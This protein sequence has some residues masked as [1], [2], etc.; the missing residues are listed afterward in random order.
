MTLL[1]TRSTGRATGLDIEAR[2]MLPMVCI[3]RP[4]AG[5]GADALVTAAASRETRQ[6]ASCSPT[7]CCSR[8]WWASLVS[9]RVTST[10]EAAIGVGLGRREARRL[11]SG[12][13]TI[14][15]A[16]PAMVLLA[17]LTTRRGPLRP[18]APRSWTGSARSPRASVVEVR[19]GG[20]GRTGSRAWWL[21]AVVC[22]CTTAAMLTRAAVAFR[23]IGTVGWDSLPG[24]MEVGVWATNLLLLSVPV[25]MPGVTGAV[26]SVKAPSCAHASAVTA[27]ATSFRQ[28]AESQATDAAKS[29]V[30][31][32]AEQALTPSCPM[33]PTA[34][35]TYSLAATLFLAALSPSASLAGNLK[36]WEIPPPTWTAP[37]PTSSRLAGWQ[38]H[39]DHMP[40]VGITVVA[41]SGTRCASEVQPAAATL[42]VILKLRATPSQI[43]CMTSG[44]HAASHSSFMIQSPT[45]WEMSAEVLSVPTLLRG[46]LR[47][48]PATEPP[49]IP[50]ADSALM[51][52]AAV[53]AEVP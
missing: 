4:K 30:P 46:A 2:R 24:A 18:P 22:R 36:P 33:L 25:I 6:E 26:V 20:V 16:G 53:G 45:G 7:L 39:V 42:P 49:P 1:G 51:G 29:R 19:C 11:S 47:E 44:A 12:R 50:A 52:A 17:T 21:P 32:V 37:P 34:L 35:L 23:G 48:R 14:F 43:V 10:A 40:E 15:H 3:G 41:L 27:R 9:W 8:S 38:R 28:A 31:V 5:A 13:T